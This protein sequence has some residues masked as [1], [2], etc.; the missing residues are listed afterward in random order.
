MHFL[1]NFPCDT[2]PVIKPPKQNKYTE[3]EMCSMNPCNRSTLHVKKENGQYMICMNPLKDS[4]NVNAPIKFKIEENVKQQRPKEVGLH[5]P[6]SDN[7][8]SENNLNIEFTPPSM[9]I[10][11]SQNLPK[12]DSKAISTQ[13]NEKDLINFEK[14]SEKLNKNSVANKKGLAA[15]EGAGKGANKKGLGTNEGA[16]G[17]KGQGTSK[18]HEGSK[19]SKLGIEKE[20]NIVETKKDSKGSGVTGG[21]ASARR[22]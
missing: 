9:G 18:G 5:V 6:M 4:E 21:K 19:Q 14:G 10:K 15:N 8:D 12:R 7:D 13:Y 3:G 16:G 22:K 17:K 1:A 2:L 20:K 11:K